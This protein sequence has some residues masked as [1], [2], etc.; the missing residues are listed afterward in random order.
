MSELKGN[1][2]LVQDCLKLGFGMMRLPHLGK[3]TM[4]D[5]I[6]IEQTKKMVDAFIAAGGKYFDTAFVYNG[7]EEATRKALCDR[8]PRDAYY[9]ANKLNASQFAC[10]NEKE[11]K[12]ELETSLERTGCGYFD[13]YLLHGIGEGNLQLY[14]AYGLWNYVRELKEK[15]LVKHIG[16]SFHDKPELLDRIL[17]EHPE[18]EFVQLQIN[19][20]DWE[21]ASI[22]SKN[23]Y[24]T[25]VRHGKPV[26]VM[27]PVKGG[28]LAAPPEPVKKILQAADPEASPASWA[29]RFA[30]SLD[31]VMMVLSG[32]SNEAQMADNLSYM[33]NFRPL[34]AHEKAVIEDAREAL[35]KIDRIPCTACHYC[36]AGC[37]V[38]MRIPEIFAVMNVYKMYGNT[39]RAKADYG[40]RA[41]TTRASECVQC[42]QCEE[43][44]PQ[45]LPI[46][47]LLRETADTLE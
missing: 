25:A 28:L 41:G 10:T 5:P 12:A 21:D 24:E 45:H 18:M 27:E 20:S 6:D 26:I 43:A 30:A 35:L 9:L 17:T 15:G 23:C 36:T 19:Y 8:Y 32:M 7:S 46:I 13:F 47:R 31:H 42:R 22:Q 44:C 1:T 37:P 38:K 16:F 34:S 29:V 4:Y 3:G 14:D 39:D 2:A 40:W 33:K 11:A